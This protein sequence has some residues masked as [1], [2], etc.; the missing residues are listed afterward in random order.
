MLMRFIAV[1]GSSTTATVVLALVVVVIAG[2]IRFDVSIWHEE[3]KAKELRS[4][5]LCAARFAKLQVAM[6]VHVHHPAKC[7]LQV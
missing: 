4:M 1:T 2:S 3:E 6:H 7:D 5:L